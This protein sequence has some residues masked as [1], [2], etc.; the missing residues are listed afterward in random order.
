[1]LVVFHM[2]L[3]KPDFLQ[4]SGNWQVIVFC[5]IICQ[6]FFIKFVFKKFHFRA[7][8]KVSQISLQKDI[9]HALPDIQL[10]AKSYQRKPVLPNIQPKPNHEYCHH[11]FTNKITSSIKFKLPLLAQEMQEMSPELTWALKQQKIVSWFQIWNF[12]DV[13]HCCD[14]PN[15]R[16]YK[17]QC[18]VN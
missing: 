13:Y 6:V 18:C 5:Q 4:V 8:K 12:Q 16:S 1:M 17:Q 2:K 7:W 10:K 9:Q 3:P 14:F 15:I 11:P